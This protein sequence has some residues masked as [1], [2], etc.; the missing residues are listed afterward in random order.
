MVQVLEGTSIAI[1]TAAAEAIRA[2]LSLPPHAF[3]YL[4]THGSLDVAHVQFFERLMDKI[5]EPQDQ[6]AIVDSARAFYRLYGDIFRS[7]PRRAQQA[8]A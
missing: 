2:S 4:T 5:T 7:L 8:A 3:T 6:Q 1:A